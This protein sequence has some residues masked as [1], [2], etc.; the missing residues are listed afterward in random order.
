MRNDA[1]STTPGTFIR[2]SLRFVSYVDRK[3]LARDLR[4]I[5]SAATEADAAT[6]LDAFEEKWGKKYPAIA[7]LWRT[8]L[9]R[10]RAVPRVPRT[11]SKD[12][13]HDERHRIAQLPVPQGAQPSRTLSLRR[14]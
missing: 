3:A 1:T 14:R 4:P 9:E 13:L 2:A 10:N 6:A 11:D 7:K 5:Y 8:P 12:P